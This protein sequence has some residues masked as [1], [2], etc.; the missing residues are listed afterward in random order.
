MGGQKVV[1]RLFDNISLHEIF[2]NQLIVIGFYL[3]QQLHVHRQGRR[4]KLK[5]RGEKFSK[6]NGELP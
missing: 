6:A 2:G 3:L 4:K 1:E 5:I